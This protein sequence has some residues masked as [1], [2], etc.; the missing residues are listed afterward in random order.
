MRKDST[1]YFGI[2]IGGTTVKIGCFD[3]EGTLIE[4][5]EIPTRRENGGAQI[6]P[7]IAAAVR[8]CLADRQAGTENLGGVGLGVPGPIL[9]DGSVN[10]CVNLG[11]GGVIV[12]GRIVGEI[13]GGGGEIGHIKMSDTETETCGCGKKGCLEQYASAT[14]IARVAK[15]IMGEELSAKEGFDRAKA[16]DEK[17]AETAAFMAEKL[18]TALSYISCVVDPQAYVIGGGVSNAGQYLIDQIRK[19][20]KESA[21]HA[22]RETKFLLAELGNDAGMYGAVKLALQ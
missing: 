18:G 10:R 21:F 1:Y 8:R 3:G 16:G 15:R 20:Y 14:G 17:A 2:D 4:K 11:W 5:F 12:D 22:S 6:L 13:F 9:S 7:D 19:Y